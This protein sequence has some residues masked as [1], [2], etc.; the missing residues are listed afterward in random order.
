MHPSEQTGEK[1]NL[2]TYLHA[3]DVCYNTVHQIAQKVTVGMNE[4]DGAALIKE[5]FS[6]VGATK[7][8]HPTKFRIASDTTKSF[9]EIGDPELKIA[10]QDLFFIDVG[11]IINDHEADFGRTFVFSSANNQNSSYQKLATD[12]EKIWN[13]VADKWRSESLTGKELYAFATKSALSKDCQLNPKM[14]GHRLGDFPHALFCK[15]GLSGTDFSPADNLWV[16]EI[17]IMQ[18]DLN[19]GAFYEDILSKDTVH[20]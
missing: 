12:A 6:K 1:F 2:T 3:R 4:A 15:D 7:F 18:P 14:A 8:W 20:K 13:E 10:E 17:H 9:R 19:R 16:L 11:P 5:E